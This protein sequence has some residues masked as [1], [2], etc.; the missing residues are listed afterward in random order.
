ML[1]S[2]TE[3][4]R[5]DIE[6]ALLYTIK[7]ARECQLKKEAEVFQQTLDNFREN[8]VIAKADPKKEQGL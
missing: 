1:I 3:E 8:V 6:T 2:I 7:H 5:V 4:E